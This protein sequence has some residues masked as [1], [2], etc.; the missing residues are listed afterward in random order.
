MRDMRRGHRLDQIPVPDTAA[1]LEDHVRYLRAQCLAVL[2]R[3]Q[4][5]GHDSTVL[6][7][8]TAALKTCQTLAALVAAGQASFPSRITVRW[9][10]DAFPSPPPGRL[11]AH[12]SQEAPAASSAFDSS[13]RSPDDPAYGPVVDADWRPL[14]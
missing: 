10:G 5:Q 12:A 9:L 7:A 8:A 4:T 2:R 6:L 1:P 3:A 11:P 14:P 13:Y